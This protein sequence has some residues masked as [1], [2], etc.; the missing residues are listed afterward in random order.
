MVDKATDLLCRDEGAGAADPHPSHGGDCESAGQSPP[1]AP[2]RRGT[3][4]GRS[5][6]GQAASSRDRR[7]RRQCK[8]HVPVDLDPV[9]RCAVSARPFAHDIPSP[10]PTY[11]SRDQRAGDRTRDHGSP[12]RLR[13]RQ[14]IR[15]FDSSRAARNAPGRSST[16]TSRRPLQV[17]VRR[18]GR[19]HGSED[20]RAND[21][22]VR[23][24]HNVQ[25]SRAAASTSARRRLGTD[26]SVGEGRGLCFT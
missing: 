19:R 5:D 9:R 12:T 16:R 15:L 26:P 20:E 23:M 8:H 21:T 14:R 25:F 7:H 3:R 24:P 4:D 2:N 22:R 13:R 1:G 6:C 11:S 18:Q 17:S 10:L